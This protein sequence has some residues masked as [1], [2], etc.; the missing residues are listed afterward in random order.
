[1]HEI[2]K[3][4]C[5]NRQFGQKSFNKSDKSG[6]VTKPLRD[7]LHC[8]RLSKGTKGRVAGQEMN[9]DRFK[10]LKING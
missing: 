5:L 3:D 1:M 4:T 10:L 6:R 8:R 9:A 7:N 2:K